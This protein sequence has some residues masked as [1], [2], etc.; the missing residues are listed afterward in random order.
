MADGGHGSI[1]TEAL[2]NLR[3]R[4]DVLPA[5]HPDRKAMMESAAT[6]YG[7]SR[8]TVNRYLR[9]WGYDHVR[10]TRE[11]AA[12]RFQAKR[13]N[14]MWQFDLSPSDLKQVTAPMWIEPGRGNP[15]LMLYSVVDVAAAGDYGNDNPADH[16][17]RD[18]VIYDGD[19]RRVGRI[20]E[21]AY[22]DRVLYDRDGRRGGHIEDRPSGDQVI[23]D[24]DGR[25]IGT[26]E[27]R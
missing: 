14:E 9:E 4:L 24:R 21:K 10:M 12:V 16:A 25:R 6:L 22:G 15:T 11:P 1:P 2:I 5:R 20:E 17:S 18:Q 8:T 7:V 27:R 26:V 23:Y 19:G 13:S 3:R